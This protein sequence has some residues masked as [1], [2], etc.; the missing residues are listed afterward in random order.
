[1]YLLHVYKL[2]RSQRVGQQV[3][4]LTEDRNS[5]ESQN[6]LEVWV[7]LIIIV[8]LFEQITILKYLCRAN[9]NISIIYV[10]QITILL[11]RIFFNITTFGATKCQNGFYIVIFAP[12]LET[13]ISISEL[14]YISYSLVLIVEKNKNLPISF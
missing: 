9:R 4:A 11:L 14:Q 6:I 5:G 1:M 12:I 8:I 10:E 2:H 7:N 3:I 13:A